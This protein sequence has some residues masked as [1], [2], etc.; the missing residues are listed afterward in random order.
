MAKL[1]F[2]AKQGD[3]QAIAALLKTAFPVQ[4]IEVKARLEDSC[5]ILHL[6]T[7][8]VLQQAPTLTFLE[9]WLRLLQP[10][11]IDFVQVQAQIQGQTNL[12][13]EKSRSLNWEP[14]PQ[15]EHQRTTQKQGFSREDTDILSFQNR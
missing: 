7:L 6:E 9:K 4:P 10:S 15:L 11:G 5:L 12:S 2:R 3:T 13:W 1:R 8:D 14:T